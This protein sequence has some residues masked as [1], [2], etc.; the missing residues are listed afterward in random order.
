[1]M[2]V[3]NRPDWRV[4]VGGSNRY[5][6]PLTARLR[7]RIRRNHRVRRVERHADHVA[8]DGEPYDHAILACHSDEALAILADPTPLEREILSQFPYESNAA[9][10]HTDESVLPR[11]RRAWACWN[12]RLDAASETR[13]A[14]T[15]NMNLLQGLRS[16]RTFCVSLNEP[17]INPNSVLRRI[18]Y[19]HPVFQPG[20]ARAQQRHAELIGHNRTSYCG[21]YWGYGFHEDGVRSALAVC[22]WFGKRLV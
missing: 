13:A 10:L 20:R 3:F 5:L 7:H 12:Y 8:I 1:M 17:G 11:E 14:V 9:V 16:R 6:D 22:E 19:R 15:Y 4:I 2:Q 18:Q 21:A